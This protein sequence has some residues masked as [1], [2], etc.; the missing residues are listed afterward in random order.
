MRN[1]LTVLFRRHKRAPIVQH[2]GMVFIAHQKRRFYPLVKSSLWSADLWEL[3]CSTSHL[4]RSNPTSPIL[5]LP[6]SHSPKTRCTSPILQTLWTGF[7]VV[8]VPIRCRQGCL[9]NVSSLKLYNP[10]LRCICARVVMR[11]Y[12]NCSCG[13]LE[14]RY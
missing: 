5:A 12:L 2:R 1:L 4:G 10:I 3:K 13:S 8:K 9:R 11:G 14:W 7:I 6:T